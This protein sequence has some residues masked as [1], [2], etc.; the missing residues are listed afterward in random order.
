MFQRTKPWLWIRRVLLVLVIVPIVLAVSGAIY[1][2]IAMAQDRRK[3]LPPAR[4]GVVTTRHD[5]SLLT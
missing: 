3:Y 2:A 4:S 1:Q 5:R